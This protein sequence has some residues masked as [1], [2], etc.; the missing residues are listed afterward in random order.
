MTI[1]TKAVHGTL[2][3]TEADSN[4]NQIQNLTGNFTATGTITAAYSDDRLK[5]RT[6]NIGEPLSKVN[7]LNGFKYIENALANSFGYEEGE[8][9]V[10]LSAQEVQKVLPEAIHLAPFDMNK[11]GMSKSG[12]RYLTV[13]YEKLVPLLVEAIKELSDKV[14]KLENK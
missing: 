7:S 5:I 1:Y 3:H 9:F 11:E 8:T 2:S 12:E 6:G 10:G 13:Q 4:M 14:D